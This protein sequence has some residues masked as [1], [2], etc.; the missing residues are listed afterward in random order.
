VEFVALSNQ[1]NI[2]TKQQETGQCRISS[3]LSWR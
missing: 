3:T 1:Q 2:V